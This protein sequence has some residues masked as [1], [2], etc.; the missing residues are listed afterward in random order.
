ML[1]HEL[2]NPL[3][4]MVTATTLLKQG[5]GAPELH[6]QLLDV[7]DRQSQQMARLLDDLLE[8][9]RVTQNKIELRRSIVD[10]REV[11]RD[12]ADAVRGMMEARQ[13]HFSV[14]SHAEPLYVDG[15]PARLQQIQVNLLSNAAKYTAPGG[16]VRLTLARDGQYASIRVSDDGAGI[17]P[18]M[19][20]SVFE[21]FVQSHRTLDRSAG[22]LGVG[23]TLARSLVGMHGGTITAES[24]G[25]GKGSTFSV[26]LPLAPPGA[27]PEVA[28]TRSRPRLGEGAR[29]V[30]VEDNEDSRELLCMLLQRAGF[31]CHTA[32]NGKEALPLIDRVQP[33]IAILDVGLPEMDGFEIARRI[34]SQPHFADLFLI[35]LT[36]YGRASDRAASRAAGFDEHVVKPVRSEELLGLLQQMRQD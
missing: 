35:A 8:A 29:I 33:Q 14:E 7:L 9:S 19:L 30:V 4:A 22:G 25:E 26:R 24:T 27:R 1:S 6:G 36:G 32:E 28:P 13:M 18:Q 10:L 2:R 3:G 31:D 21:L 5:G 15:D 11:V 17:A 23:L 16:H 12:A 20:D 34:R